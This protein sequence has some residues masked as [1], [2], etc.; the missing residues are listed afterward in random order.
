MDWSS[1][2]L[3][4]AFFLPTGKKESFFPHSSLGMLSYAT[5]THPMTLPFGKLTPRGL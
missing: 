1:V 2:K 4:V 3:L 5:T